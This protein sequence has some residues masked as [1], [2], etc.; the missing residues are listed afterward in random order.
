[1]QYHAHIFFDLDHEQAAIRLREQL[2]HIFP[3]RIFVGRLLCRAVG[4]L[5]K[6]MFQLEY[7]NVDAIYVQQVLT[8]KCLGFSVLIHPIL[9]N[10]I[11]AHTV[12]ATWLGTPLEL[13]LDQL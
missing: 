8:Q 9:E 2:L 11:L 5:P 3:E 1:M 6:P 4:P 7:E 12:Y 10:E 13:R